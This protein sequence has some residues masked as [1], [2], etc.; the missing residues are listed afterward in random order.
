[1]SQLD[2]WFADLSPVEGPIHG[3]FERPSEALDAEVAWLEE[4]WLGLRPDP[5]TE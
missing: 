2:F 5:L 1:M 3:P 4:N